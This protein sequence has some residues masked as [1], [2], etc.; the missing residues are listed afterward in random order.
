MPRMQESGN[1]SSQSG[2]ELLNV[3]KRFGQVAAVRDLTLTV[4]P[5]EFFCLLGPSGC[6]KTTTLHMIAGFIAPDEGDIR[7]MGRSITSI[8][9]NKRNVGVVFQDYAL[10]PHMT[11]RA[12]IGY[13][14]AIRRT[15]PDE[16]ARKVTAL[17]DLVKL[18]HAADR[19]PREMSGGEQ[20]RTAVARA[21]AISPGVLLLDEPLSNLDAKLRFQV[22]QELKR[23]QRETGVTSV[24]VTHD[25]QEAFA[26]ADRVAVMRAGRVEQLGSLENLYKSPV[27]IFVS[28]FI[29]Q[30]NLLAGVVLEVGRVITVRGESHLFEANGDAGL[31][32]RGDRVHV[33]VRPEAIRI[34]RERPTTS[35]SY[36]GQI[37]QRSYFGSF[38]HYGVRLADGTHVEVKTAPESDLPLGEPVHLWWEPSAAALVGEAGS[39]SEARN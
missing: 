29:G 13:G 19:R 34:S 22:G 30:A 7:L 18:E 3:T 31:C 12:N 4:M 33:V 14:L 15:P 5:G 27:N 1:A 32:K 20:Q 8:P 26:L 21:L 36:E 25:Q 9:P 28:Q 16:I 24:M 11:A 6:G 17:L 10:F 23:I 39:P 35:R 37:V 2:L 38:A